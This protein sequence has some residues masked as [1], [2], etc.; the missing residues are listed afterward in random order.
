MTITEPRPPTP[1]VQA[2]DVPLMQRVVNDAVGMDIPRPN[3]LRNG[4]FE[5]WRNGPGPFSQPN[6]ECAT[7]WVVFPNANGEV[8]TITQIA[9]TAPTGSTSAL[10]MQGTSDG[11]NLIAQTLDPALASLNGVSVSLSAMV[12]GP[13]GAQ[14]NA[15]VGII[16]D[17]GYTFQPPLDCT[18]DWQMLRFIAAIPSGAPQPV[19][20]VLAGLGQYAFEFDNTSLVVGSIPS[21]YQPTLPLP[22]PIGPPGPQGPMGPQGVAGPQGPAQPGRRWMGAWQALIDYVVRDLATA[23]DGSV[24]HCIA[25][26][27]STVA[28]Y[29]DPLH[30]E[31]FVA[32]GQPGAPG[33]Q[34]PIGPQG[35]E[36]PTGPVGPAGPEGPVG[37]TGPQGD[38]GPPGAAGP[39]GDPGPVGPQ[40][41]QGPPGDA[42]A[43]YTSVWTWNSQVTVP[44][45]TGQV[46][47]DTGDWAT[48][49]TLYIDDHNSSNVDL[50][51]ELASI[52][53]GD[54]I[55]MQ[56]KTDSTRWVKYE[57]AGSEPLGIA[58]YYSFPLIYVDGLGGVPNSGTDIILSVLT[59]GSPVPQW[60]TGADPP[61]PTLGIA[62]DMYLQANGDVWSYDN[63]EDGPSVWN[64]TSTN[65]LGPTG[66]QG[67][68]GPPGEQGVPGTDG[69]AGPQGLEGSPGAQGPAGP[70]GPQGL[71][72]PKG[73]TGIVGPQ[74]E[75]GPQGIT[76]TNGAQGLQGIQGPQGVQGIQGPPGAQG[77]TGPQG[78]VGVSLVGTADGVTSGP[79]TLSTTYVDIPD[80]TVAINPTAP[81]TVLAWMSLS[82]QHTS[83]T[84]DLN[85]ALNI[86]GGVATDPITTRVGTNN[87]RTALM[88][89]GVWTNVAAGAHSVRGRW[90]TSAGTMTA[91]GVNR[92]MLVQQII[93]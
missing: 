71:P 75:A 49:T 27:T 16:G 54:N 24:Y 61:L 59:Q 63:P 11:A 51:R 33:A 72:G 57:V 44:P 21:N 81:C 52:K 38:I 17:V 91:V 34:G 87:G 62:G 83:N 68:P 36:G 1:M 80:M 88:V 93:S 6:Q 12:K 19:T 82:L 48:A 9:S 14:V 78:P 64:L 42:N 29:D 66:A 92:H 3:L 7:A 37:T 4:G 69:A 45:N 5:E 40:G 30:W 35:D 84:A 13:V 60:Y 90:N 25:D 65:I 89:F 47:S 2:T 43:T 32:G 70:E 56:H 15:V 79:T 10:A 23:D 55:R 67:P 39:Q 85:I 20:I 26:V 50:S 41:Q 58:S 8:P 31:L 46:R 28:P 77:A 86:D 18:G 53:Q 22:G 73:D 76:G 74:G